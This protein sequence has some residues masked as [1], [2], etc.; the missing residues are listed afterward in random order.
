MIKKTLSYTLLWSGIFASQSIA[1]VAQQSL[2][3]QLR[4]DAHHPSKYTNRNIDQ[5]SLFAPESEGDSD[6]GEQLILKKTPRRTPFNVSA[7]SNIYYT[8][9]VT[10][11]NTNT[12]T[13]WIWANNVHTSW[14]P[15]IGDNLFLDI[16]INHELF[17]YET[18]TDLDFAN[19]QTQLGLVKVLENSDVVLFAEVEHNYAR[20]N[21]ISDKIHATTT[22]NLGA[23]KT[24]LHNP[25]HSSYIGTQLSWDIDS[26]SSLAERDEILIKLGHRY[27]LNNKFRLTAYSDLSW[28]RY[29]QDRDDFSYALGLHLEYAL[30][31]NANLYTSINYFNNNS[32]NDANDYSTTLGVLGAGI[33]AS[34]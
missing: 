3:D 16:S 6:L 30:T 34:F 25:K 2:L 1:E 27:N 4:D 29:E 5:E 12:Q 11:A 10:N 20:N 33:K 28:F 23:N 8:N 24:F 19:T 13:G 17:H 14:T 18:N 15:K 9:N 22:L 31:A 26:S 21:L 7:N 32:D